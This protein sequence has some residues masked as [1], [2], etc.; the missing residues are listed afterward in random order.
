MIAQLILYNKNIMGAKQSKNDMAICL[1][2]FNPSKTKRILM[3][4][5]YSKNQFII[6]KLPVFTI[7]L[8][9][10]GQTPEIPDAIH[11]HSNSVMFHK[12]NLYRILETKIPKKYKKLAF[13]DCDILFSSPKWYSETSKLLNEYDVVQPFENAHWMDLTYSQIELSRKTVLEMKGNTWSF[14]YHPGF[15][16]CMT[17]GWYNYSGFF[18]YALSGSG[19]T[20]SAAAWLKKKFPANFQS[21][22]K[23]LKH[24]YSKFL[25]KTSPKITYLKGVDVY[26]LYHG[27]R[28]NRQY[29]VRHKLLDVN[30]NIEEIVEANSEGVY[31]WKNPTKWNPV[32]INYFEK[33]DDDSLSTGLV[34]IS[35]TS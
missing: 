20:L 26:H 31:E 9:Y 4:Y 2:V 29:S 3:N 24:Q 12:E 15:A 19:D 6:Q 35:L 7:E 33:R 27:S 25:D 14:N 8:V 32:F 28:D 1:V 21:L 22:P 10:A 16:W 13:L 17:R 30:I 11:V 5:F 34:T 23:S 18:D